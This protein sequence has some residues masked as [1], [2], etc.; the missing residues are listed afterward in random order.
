MTS[1]HCVPHSI[2]HLPCPGGE[3]PCS[4]SW[5]TASGTSSPWRLRLTPMADPTPP[6]TAATMHLHTGDW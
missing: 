2:S 3:E 4:T 6:T 5:I 1:D